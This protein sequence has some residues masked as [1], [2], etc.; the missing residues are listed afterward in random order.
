[1]AEKCYRCTSA[2]GIFNKQIGCKN[3]GFAFCKKCL[4]KKASIPKLSNEKG[5]VCDRCF[6]I[7]T[8]KA[9]PV[10]I[11]PPEALAKRVQAASR[12]S[13]E[14]QSSLKSLGDSQS[15]SKG[16]SKE[17][18]AISERL[19]KLKADRKA[20]MPTPS[21]SEIESRFEKLKEDTR[22][23]IPSE[24][25]IAGRLAIVC[26]RDPTKSTQPSAL[27]PQVKKTQQEQIENLLE[28]ISQEVE[29]DSR[30]SN[31]AGFQNAKNDLSREDAY[32]KTSPCPM[33]NIGVNATGS[34]TRG[35]GGKDNW[36][37]VNHLLKEVSDEM[38][39]D[40]KKAINDL[41]KDKEL[42]ERVQR[43]KADRK[44][45]GKSCEENTETHDCDMSDSDEDD[46]KATKR[47][48]KQ[49]IEESRLDEETEQ[50]GMNVR[51]TEAPSK[52][53]KSKNTGVD[54]SDM[55]E[56]SDEL[57]WC[58]I[59]NNDAALRCRGCDGDLYCKRCYKEGH[60]REDFEDHQAIPYKMRK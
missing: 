59:C 32:S 15:H 11:A 52:F 18:A 60:D 58:C 31:T 19:Q 30:F 39:I 2:F 49:M 4:T 5:T 35:V 42:W 51:H 46:E 21:Q 9:Q 53:G 50:Q 16:L 57:P 7:L 44:A 22:S 23:A 10:S 17:D 8:G 43:L 1:M 13:G 47:I 55:G 54:A 27:K 12:A 56:E 26:G 33:Y 45:L 20:A 6:D 29:I 36:S 25:D 41:K 14:R 3:C 48:I 34:Q 37:E 40:A 24:Q 28:E 38:E